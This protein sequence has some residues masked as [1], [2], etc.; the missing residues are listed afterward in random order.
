M[1][2]AVDASRINSE[3]QYLWTTD[4]RQIKNLTEKYVSIISLNDRVGLVIFFRLEM[5]S[6]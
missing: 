3:P 6:S 5:L 4:L 1:N 2:I